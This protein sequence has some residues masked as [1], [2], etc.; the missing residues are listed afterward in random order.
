MCYDLRGYVVNTIK[1]LDI[2]NEDFIATKPTGQ[3]EKNYFIFEAGEI[4]FSLLYSRWIA[5][6]WYHILRALPLTGSSIHQFALALVEGSPRKNVREA[7]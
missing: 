2:E 4:E 3:R 5:I 1:T 7:C 6:L